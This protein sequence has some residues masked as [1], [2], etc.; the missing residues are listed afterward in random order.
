MTELPLYRILKDQTRQKIL[1]LIGEKGNASYTDILTQLNV[2]TGKLNYHLKLLAPFLLKSNEGY[3]LN[4]TGENALS[5]LMKFQ[6]AQNGNDKFYRSLSWVLVPLS[7]IFLFVPNIYVQVSG[8]A[9]LFVGIFF[10]YNS[11]STRMRTWELLAVL[12]MALVA[13][14]LGALPQLLVNY[15]SS[16]TFGVLYSPLIATIYSIVYFSTFVAWALTTTRRW[17]LAISAMFSIS[18]FF[19]AVMISAMVG[20]FAGPPGWSSI[21]GIMPLPSVFLIASALSE[22]AVRLNDRS[23]EVNSR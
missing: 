4:E 22:A 7:L 21:E 6:T 8:M 23:L 18:I 2:S 1:R 13:G 9:A 11:G 10:F 12:S 15:P 3:S 5:I 16:F 14:S 19:F 17:I 20:P